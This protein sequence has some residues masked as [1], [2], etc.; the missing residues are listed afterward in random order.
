[1]GAR[2]ALD[3]Q[4][5]ILGVMDI[6][7]H[8]AECLARFMTAVRDGRRQDYVRAQTIVHDVRT[9]HGDEAAEIARQELFKYIRSEK[10][11][12]ATASESASKES[13]EAPPRE[14]KRTGRS[15][16]I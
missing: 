10:P 6:E 12:R 7:Q 16:R 1:M 3:Y 5:R 15:I 13:P 14:V 4:R 11:T 9:T 8:K 2:V